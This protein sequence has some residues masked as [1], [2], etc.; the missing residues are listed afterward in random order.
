MVAFPGHHPT[1]PPRMRNTSI[2]QIEVAELCLRKWWLQRVAAVKVPRR[3]AFSVGDSMHQVAE[4]F[5]K[6]EHDIYP[7]GWDDK[8]SDEERHWLKTRVGEA[9]AAGV[10]QVIPGSLVEVPVCLLLGARDSRGLP[11][12]AQPNLTHRTDKQTGALVR[13][14]D[15][16]TQLIDGS[17]LPAG[18][19]SLPYLSAFI[20]LFDPDHILPKVIDHKSAKNKRYAKKKKDIAESVQMLTYSA[21]PMS[22][23]NVDQVLCRYNVFLKDMSARNGA[24]EVSDTINIDQ[25]IER[26]NRTLQSASTMENVRKCVPAGEKKDPERGIDFRRVEGAVDTR[27]DQ[28]IRKVCGAFGGCEYRE[29]CHGMCSIVQLT[30]KLDDRVTK[31]ISDQSISGSSISGIDFSKK[32]LSIQPTTPPQTEQPPKGQHMNTPFGTSAPI[33]PGIGGDAYVKDPQ[34]LQQYRARI[35]DITNE[36]VKVYIWPDPQT[37]PQFNT[38]PPSYIVA[39]LAQASLHAEPIPGIPLARYDESLRQAGLDEQAITWQPA[40]Q[41]QASPFAGAPTAATEGQIP[42][43]QQNLTAPPAQAWQPQ[44]GDM[45]Q[46]LPS[47]HSFWSQHAG[48]Q[49]QVHSVAADNT[50]TVIIDGLM[51]PDVASGRFAP[52]PAPAPEEGVQQQIP[53]S[54]ATLTEAAQLAPDMTGGRVQEH[55]QYVGKDIHIQHA[56]IASQFRGVCV[57]VDEEGIHMENFQSPIKWGLV[58]SV[59]LAENVP[60][61]GDEKDAKRVEDKQHME[62]QT[63]ATCL[64]EIDNLL[65]AGEEKKQPGLGKRDMAKVRKYL[66]KAREL[67]ASGEVPATSPTPAPTSDANDQTGYKAGF[68]AA[69]QQMG[70]HI[71]QIQTGVVGPY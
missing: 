61:P 12:V 39:P 58:G 59:D 46:V 29:A 60:I 31:G 71:Q 4:H 6:G 3:R 9:I 48:K 66:D 33:K 54:T 65:K 17:L 30:T 44:Q 2:S 40:T 28:V 45:V 16:P 11:L 43:P 51:Y 14:I 10:W 5:H 21:Y 68:Q 22:I 15:Q 52:A 32:P 7:Q 38:L 13:V 69:C 36:G 8:L 20:D 35:K 49:A 67:M 64:Q 41:Q 42:P 1:P 63:I 47:D 24:F 27:N 18:W 55:Q 34:A 62:S 23:L 19:D 70:A 37:P 56:E 53:M 50:L 25:V 57:A 26:W